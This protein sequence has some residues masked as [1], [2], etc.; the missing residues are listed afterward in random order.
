ML[1]IY[2]IMIIRDYNGKMIKFNNKKY[3]SEKKLYSSLW[4]IMFNVEI[5]EEETVFDKIK[6]KIKKI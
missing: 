2:Y 5:K 4:K 3:N 6:N 1:F